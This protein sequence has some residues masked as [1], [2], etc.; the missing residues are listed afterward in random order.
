MTAARGT[1]LITGA[2]GFIGTELVRSFLVHGWSVVGAGRTRPPAFPEQAAWR[3][4]DLRW[5]ALPPD[6]FEGVDAVVHGAVVKQSDDPHSFDVNVNAGRLLLAEAQQRGIERVT[7]LSSLAAHDGALSQYGKS[8]YALERWY[9]ERGALVV[10]PGLVLGDGAI[11]GAMVAYLRTHRFVPLFGAGT[12][13][14][15]TVYVGDLAE[16]VRLAVEAGLR[17]T[18][19]AAETEPVPYR[20]FYEVLCAE[21]G[22]RPTF[23]KI[24][25]WA[26]EAA[27]GAAGMLRIRLPID[28]D[29]LLGLRTMRADKGAALADPRARTFKENIERVLAPAST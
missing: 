21:L 4:Y 15:Q 3:A 28:R 1:V 19:T 24:P 8:K 23:V 11:F 22:V 10:R 13:P 17:G 2:G 29:N 7:F 16:G 27:I 18:F 6:F 9:D 26:A 14:L 20:R 25:F 5:T 12:Q